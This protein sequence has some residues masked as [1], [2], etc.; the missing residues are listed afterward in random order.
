[1]KTG[2]HLLLNRTPSGPRRYVWSPLTGRSY[3]RLPNPILSAPDVLQMFLQA[4]QTL[5]SG[6]LDARG[7]NVR[8]TCLLLHCLLVF[9]GIAQINLLVPHSR[10]APSPAT[11]KH[12]LKV[13]ASGDPLPISVP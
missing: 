3:H 2:S 5:C 4:K 7:P 10:A 6:P 11:R 12:P 9:A 8:V 1:M 13:S